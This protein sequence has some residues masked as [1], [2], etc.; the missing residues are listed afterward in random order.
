[1][2]YH[3]PFLKF[4]IGEHQAFELAVRSFCTEV[5]LIQSDFKEEQFLTLPKQMMKK[6]NEKRQ[7]TKRSKEEMTLPEID[8]LPEVIYQ[9][10]NCSL[11]KIYL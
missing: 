2:Y 8:I 3:E 6:M 4:I 5:C 10:Q 1:M 9:N 7:N 11:T